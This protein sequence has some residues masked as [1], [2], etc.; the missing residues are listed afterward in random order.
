MGNVEWENRERDWA[1]EFIY[2]GARGSTV[3]DYAVV[4][5][6]INIRIKSF[7]RKSGLRSFTFGIGNC[8]EEKKRTGEEDKENGMR[9]NRR[10]KN[11]NSL[12]QNS[13]PRI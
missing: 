5:E 7:R 1:G 9:K 11:E 8:G 10:K 3:K 12:G 6:E 2:V 4:S 13:N